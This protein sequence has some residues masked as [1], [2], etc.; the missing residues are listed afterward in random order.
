M[1]LSGLALLVSRSESASFG[2]L[3]CCIASGAPKVKHEASFR[4][5]YP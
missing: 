4:R 3:L 2:A 1:E 5:I